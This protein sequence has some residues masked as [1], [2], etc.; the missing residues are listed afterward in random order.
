MAEA[1]AITLFPNP[2]ERLIMLSGIENIHSV[3]VF[4]I[5]GK[6]QLFRAD[7]SS[8]IINI[9]GLPSGVYFI[10]IISDQNSITKKFIKQ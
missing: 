10:K 6:I 1:N 3:E 8:S 2:S 4:D 5:I 9:E 7:I